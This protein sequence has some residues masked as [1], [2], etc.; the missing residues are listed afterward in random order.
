LEIFFSFGFYNDVSPKGFEK[1]NP[2][3]ARE[4]LPKL[5]AQIAVALA[6][7]RAAGDHSTRN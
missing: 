1:L 6:W 7:A 2:W 4:V 3:F 5:R